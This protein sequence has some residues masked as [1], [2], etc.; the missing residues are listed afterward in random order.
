MLINIYSRVAFLSCKPSMNFSIAFLCLRS[1]KAVVLSVFFEILLIWLFKSTTFAIFQEISFS[2][3]K[4]FSLRRNGAISSLLIYSDSKFY[5]IFAIFKICT[6][7][8]LVV[9]CPLYILPVFNKWSKIIS[10]LSS[11]S[12]NPSLRRDPLIVFLTAPIWTI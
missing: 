3:A 1:F 2:R 8:L 6:V 4:E 10:I 12:S 5:P 7:D 11:T 9:V